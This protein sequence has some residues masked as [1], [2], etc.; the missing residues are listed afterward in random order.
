VLP[1]PGRDGPITARL[2]RGAGEGSSDENGG[3]QQNQ[4]QPWRNSLHG[5]DITTKGTLRWRFA[6]GSNAL[7]NIPLAA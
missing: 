1:V 2:G 7:P 5:E 4:Q 6:R 3:P